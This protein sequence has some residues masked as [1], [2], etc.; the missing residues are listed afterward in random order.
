MLHR[1]THRVAE[2]VKTYKKQTLRRPYGMKK[3][4]DENEV[5]ALVY[6]VLVTLIYGWWYENLN[7]IRVASNIIHTRAYV[8]IGF[9]AQRSFR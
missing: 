2:F 9:V 6:I 4:S 1:K 3:F 8:I 7:V 5:H